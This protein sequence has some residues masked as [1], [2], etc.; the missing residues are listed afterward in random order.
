MPEA[1]FHV[2]Q[3][4]PAMVAPYSHAAQSGDWLFLTGQMPIGADGLVPE[5]IEAQTKTCIDNLR[6]VMRRCGFEN[7]D[8]LQARVFLTRF[9][10]HYERMNAVYQ[11]MLPAGS[12]PARTCV[13]VTALARGCDVEIDFVV[14]KR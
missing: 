12:M 9:E 6:D 7:G 3:D 5:G 10:Q 14:R 8:V 13:G 1:I 11:S 2:F 4:G